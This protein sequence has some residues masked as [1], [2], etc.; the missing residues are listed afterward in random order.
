MRF[1]PDLDDLDAVAG[2][3]RRLIG[4]SWLPARTSRFETAVGAL[5]TT[6]WWPALAGTPFAD[7]FQA[8]YYR[9][10]AFRIEELPR[11]FLG[12][13]WDTDACHARGE[14]GDTRLERV[15][16]AA[17]VE[18]LTYRDALQALIALGVFATVRSPG[19][20]LLV[21]NP[22]PPVSVWVIV[23]SFA[24]RGYGSPRAIEFGAYRTVS[25]DLL[26]QARWAKDGVLRETPE[27][28][29]SRLG[30]SLDEVAGALNLL[31][32]LGHDV[33]PLPG[34]DVDTRSTIA[35]C[36]ADR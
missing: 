3:P 4:R 29:A 12:W 34:K 32:A 23:E 24:D 22:A 9:D 31:S 16:R 25:E 35:L 33:E 26:H 1:W 2:P 11:P 27:R 5:K 8:L 14:E 36:A 20:E 18:I 19:G 17:G 10:R 21:P 13:T 7:I 6:G 28:I 30:L 15:A